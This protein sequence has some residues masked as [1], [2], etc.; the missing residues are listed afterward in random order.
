MFK[1]DP[2]YPAEKLIFY[3]LIDSVTC[4]VVPPLFFLS[5]LVFQFISSDVIYILQ[6]HDT[7]EQN[8]KE[9]NMLIMSKM[10]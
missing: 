4:L 9:V 5:F 10:Q 7:Q 3:F 6:K 8:Q 2:G 1:K